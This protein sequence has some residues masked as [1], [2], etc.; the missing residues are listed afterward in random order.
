MNEKERDAILKHIDQIERYARQPQNGWLLTELQKRFG[1][2]TAVLRQDNR[3]PL[4]SPASQAGIV[5]DAQKLANIEHY[6]A[7]DYNIDSAYPRVDYS[8]VNDE[9]IRSQLI[10][11]WRESQRLRF[12][13]RQHKQD[14]SEYCRYAHMQAEGLVN[15]LH[16]QRA[17]GALDTEWF[18]RLIN[19]INERNAA[20][21][22]SFVLNT[23]RVGATSLEHVDYNTKK[24]IM[25]HLMRHYNYDKVVE[26][27]VLSLRLGFIM[28][29]RNYSSH[30]GLPPKTNNYNTPPSYDEIEWAIR[31]VAEFV[32]SMLYVT[33]T[34][35][36]NQWGL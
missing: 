35:G 19:Q 15:Y 28:Q 23:L 17:G 13:L 29:Y 5:V 25:L 9:L 16:F 11:D 31:K 8:F 36:D 10:A 3:K 34:T 4:Q 33:Q 20:E 12:G 24:E 30:R 1:G 6:L 7:L 18:R 27:K 21:G 2:A 26:V 14:F 32:L 22:N